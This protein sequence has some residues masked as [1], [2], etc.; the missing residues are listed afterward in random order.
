MEGWSVVDALYFCFMTT[1][2]IGYGDLVPTTATSKIFTIVYSILSIGVFVAA[3]AKLVIA[4]VSR[5]KVINEHK[6]HN[7][8]K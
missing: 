3:M 4:I 6:K 5:R 2:T 7:I 8:H 1:S